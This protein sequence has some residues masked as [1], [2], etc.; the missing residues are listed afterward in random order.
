MKG[1]ALFALDIN[2]KAPG[3]AEAVGVIKNSVDGFFGGSQNGIDQNLTPT[4]KST[5][6]NNKT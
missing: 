2:P 1:R 3:L 4:N 5:I 6:I